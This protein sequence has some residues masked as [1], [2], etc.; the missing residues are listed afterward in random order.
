[1]T[2]SSVPTARLSRSFLL[3]GFGLAAIGAGSLVLL[4]IASRALSAE[5]FAGFGIWF[6]LV[7]LVAFG[8]FSP[9]ES[10]VSRSMLVT[11]GLTSL[12]K[13]HAL[14]YGSVVLLSVVTPGVLMQSIVI[15]RLM[16]GSWALMAVTLIYVVVL[17]IQA[18][19]RGVA[20]GYGE[21]RPLFWQFT[22]DGV[23]RVALALAAA[24]YGASSTLAFASCVA[25]SATIGVLGGFVAI[26]SRTEP[27]SRTITTGLEVR[28]LL[29]LILAA[30]GAQLL[31][32]GAPPILSLA[33]HNDARTMAALV[34]ALTLTR[35]PLL[36]TSAIQAPLLPPMV[37]MIERGD[38]VGVWV[39]IRRLLIS[40]G[41]AGLLAAIIGWRIGE[42]LL[43]TYLGSDNVASSKALALLASSG[44]ALLAV[45]SVQAALIASAGHRALVNAWLIGVAVFA[46]TIS[47]NASATTVA[48]FAIAFGTTATLTSMLVGLRFR[49]R[50]V[51]TDFDIQRTLLA[52]ASKPR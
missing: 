38:T 33:G 42:T 18:F 14:I 3:V 51:H 20:V 9:L 49:L 24:H 34:G 47:H 8:L 13:R 23:L 43:R 39:L 7:N 15:P 28:A 17:G 19:Q 37:A 50:R 22:T 2:Q 25:V 31:M 12:M 40:L 21:Y 6:G 35:I 32:N 44:V 41:L 29:A 10:A 46:I 30:I 16:N 26:K 36:F 52:R 45:L 11:G 48:P 4:A 27:E 5:S 1:M